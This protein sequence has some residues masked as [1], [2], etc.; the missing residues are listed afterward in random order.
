M[1]DCAAWWISKYCRF[2]HILRALPYLDQ[3]DFGW[4]YGMSPTFT[5]QQSGTFTRKIVLISGVL[6]TIQNVDFEFPH[7]LGDV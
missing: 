6:T 7:L 1:K 4:G 2:Q 3:Y 5:A